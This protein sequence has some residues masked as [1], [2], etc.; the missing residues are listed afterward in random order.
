MDWR[1]LFSAIGVAWHDRGANTSQGH[2]TIRCPWCRDDPSH[3]LSIDEESGA[4]Y[5]FRDPTRHFG[6]SPY[7]LLEKLYD[8]DKARLL[9][10]YG[11]SGRINAP[12]I[13]QPQ[14]FTNWSKFTS[15]VESPSALQYLRQRGFQQAANV[16]AN[17]DLRIAPVGRFAT[18][19]LMP[20]VWEGEVIGFTGRTWVQGRE[21]KYLS[22]DNTSGGAMYLPRAPAKEQTLLLV[23]GPMDALKAAAYGPSDIL[24][25]AILG[26]AL[27]PLRLE[28]LRQLAS[29]RKIMIT[30]D[31]DQA[32]GQ[33]RHFERTIRRGSF[34]EKLADRNNPDIG[35][36]VTVKLPYGKKD[37]G[38]MEPNEI[39]YWLD[40]ALTV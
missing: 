2:I 34:G 38:E 11:Y 29:G 12:E 31:V 30:F 21:P 7:K 22:E 32:R 40:N 10:Q 13:V 33:S 8:G 19:V 5:C 26:L 3:H 14:H 1:G 6:R 35:N 37:V 9:R 16:A 23:E 27:P 18:R 20:F 15:A 25:A 39:T 24:P 36:I 28:R 4:Y 17:F